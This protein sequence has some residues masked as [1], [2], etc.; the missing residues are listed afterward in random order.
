MDLNQAHTANLE[1]ALKNQINLILFFF[2]EGYE[3]IVLSGRAYKCK[4]TS[5]G[6]G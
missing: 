1:F 2:T 4:K 5:A 6:S 3:I